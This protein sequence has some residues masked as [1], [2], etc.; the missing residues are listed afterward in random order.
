[1]KVLQNLFS[2]QSAKV[3]NK[4]IRLIPHKT[5][6]LFQKPRLDTLKF[7]I[8]H[9]KVNLTCAINHYL[10]KQ[11]IISVSSGIKHINSTVI[12][13]FPLSFK[14]LV[15]WNANGAENL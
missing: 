12:A 11:Y 5:F 13:C 2:I 7:N 9:H 10:P 15:L 6:L 1:M 3:A 8:F 4:I 14:N